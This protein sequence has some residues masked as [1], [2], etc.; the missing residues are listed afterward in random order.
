MVGVGI[1]VSFWD[2]IFSGAMLV[3]GRVH[4]GEST[5]IV[6]SNIPTGWFLWLMVRNPVV[7]GWANQNA[8]GDKSTWHTAFLLLEG[9]TCK[10]LYKPTLL[11]FFGPVSHVFSTASMNTL[12]QAVEFIVFFLRPSF[13]RG[14][15]CRFCL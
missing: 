8:P 9:M 1:L 15:S 14:T 11:C 7:G 13:G 12:K 10:A 5:V 4:Q 3:S 2:S 6:D